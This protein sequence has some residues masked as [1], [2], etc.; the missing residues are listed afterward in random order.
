MLEISDI[1]NFHAERKG[2]DLR[3]RSSSKGIVEECCLKSCSYIELVSYC[4]NKDIIEDI[5]R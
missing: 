1:K 2:S 5:K 4:N 3:K